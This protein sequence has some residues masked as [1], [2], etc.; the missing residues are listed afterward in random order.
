MP[1]GRKCSLRGSLP[2]FTKAADCRFLVLSIQSGFGTVP[3][4][5]EERRAASVWTSVK[6]RSRKPPIRNRPL[7]RPNT[8]SGSCPASFADMDATAIQVPT[9]VM[10]KKL[11]KFSENTA[12]S[13]AAI[14]PIADRM[15]TVQIRLYL[16]TALSE[17]DHSTVIV[18]R[19]RTLKITNAPA[20][21]LFGLLQRAAALRSTACCG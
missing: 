12:N 9:R 16:R 15:P 20:P 2:K 1:S 6:K 8:A 11:G 17:I 14:S 7:N 19:I 10:V 21:P 13:E 5:L 3:D 4:S 18:S